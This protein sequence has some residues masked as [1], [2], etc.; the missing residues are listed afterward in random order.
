MNRRRKCVPKN[1]S[2]LYLTEESAPEYLEARAERAHMNIMDQ[3]IYRKDNNNSILVMTGH[4]SDKQDTVHRFR[5]EQMLYK[6]YVFE[7]NGIRT[8]E[9]KKFYEDYD[10]IGDGETEYLP[11]NDNLNHML[12]SAVRYALGRRTYMVGMTC[13]YISTLIPKLSDQAISVMERDIREQ[14]KVT[15]LN[16]GTVIDHLGDGCDRADWVKLLHKLQDEMAKRN[17]E[18]WN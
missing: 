8:V 7:P 18:P 12:M 5:I 13:D 3:K 17:L 1:M 11:L 6:Y 4:Y 16:D 15:T 2:C 10:E 14:D 9:P